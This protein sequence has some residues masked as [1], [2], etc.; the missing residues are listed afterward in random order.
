MVRSE[1]ELAAVLAHE[2]AHVV[3]FLSLVYI[4]V[5]PDVVV[6]V[7]SLLCEPQLLLLRVV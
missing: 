5:C 3:R 6:Y 4:F 1:A 2:S 7:V